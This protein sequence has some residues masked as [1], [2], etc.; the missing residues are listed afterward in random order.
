MSKPTGI[1][2]M[3]VNI[4][5]NSGIED[6]QLYIFLQSQTQIYQI[7]NQL[8]SVFNTPKP[9]QTAAPSVTL[10]ELKNSDGTYSLYINSDNKLKSGRLYFSN[11]ASAVQIT[12]S[13]GEVTAI[14]GPSPTAD[15]IFDFVELT[16]NAGSDI[17]LDTTQ[18]DQFGVPITVQVSPN[19]PNFP[20]GT[21]IIIGDSRKTVIDNFNTLCSKLGFADY[22]PCATTSQSI[23]RLLGPQHVIDSQTT[24]TQLTGDLAITTSGNT[25]TGTFT[26]STGG[27]GS[28]KVGQFASGPGIPAVATVQSV[29]SSTI[30][31]SGTKS[32]FG[33]NSSYQKVEIVFYERSATTLSTCMDNAI[34]NFF[35]HYEQNTLYLVANGTNSGTE[36][37]AGKVK[38]DFILPSGL[39]DI[40]GN[41]D[42]QY[43]VFE[44]TGT[45][46]KYNAATN[47]LTKLAAPASG[48]S[49]VYQ[50]FYPYFSTNCSESPNSN[51]LTPQGPPPPPEWW[52]AGWGANVSTAKKYGGPLGNINTISPASQM[53]LACAGVF[54]DSSYQNWAY[55]N[56]SGFELQ[57]DTVLGNLENQVVTMLN[58]GIS[59]N[60]EGINNLH[61]RVGF[62]NS[63]D[64]G[65]IDLKNVQNFSQ[66]KPVALIQTPSSAITTIKLSD[67]V[68]NDSSYKKLSNPKGFVGA[69]TSGKIYFQGTH[70]Q[71]FTIDEKNAGVLTA[72][73]N[74]SPSNTVSR[75]SFDPTNAE[76]SFFWESAV[77]LGN[78]QAEITCSFGPVLDGHYATLHLL[79]PNSP[80]QAVTF[81]C[82]I[83]TDN[84][85]IVEGMEMTTLSQFSQPMTVYYSA[86][87]GGKSLILHS[88]IP[89]KPFNTG[90]LLFS[91][92]YPLKD[93]EPLG[94]WNIYSYYFHNGVLGLDIPTIDGRGYAFPFDDNGGYSSDLTLNLG[95]NNPTGI[96]DITLNKVI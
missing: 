67:V 81:S 32:S 17:N 40:N 87:N 37:Y 68:A 45:G 58:R 79:D 39:T 75:I 63:N 82:D 95:S 86:N 18:I 94:E 5:N 53:V 46:Y 20:N 74:T 47:E 6:S 43:T 31:I 54:G 36:I 85:N 71:N 24:Q 64:I 4:T 30:T 56:L 73:P 92:F 41:A 49:N 42:T 34:Y 12:Q 88:P 61:T 77:D 70:I 2:Y 29:Q 27:T 69:N 91:N 89:F 38:T 66:T 65:P 52:N 11:S 84:T 80:A 3:E 59:P 35:K 62:I 78:T 44:F 26:I 76:L 7:N 15:F 10:S 25:Y 33:T 13:G 23:P 16:L 72:V 48:Q 55:H 83:G 96:L 28:V 8:A 93:N 14:N 22:A 9:D 51:D 21:G 57:D 1:S 60:A 90:I 19:D 50:V